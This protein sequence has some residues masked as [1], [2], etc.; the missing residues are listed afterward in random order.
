MSKS[1]Y[2]DNIESGLATV[3][4]ILQ[5]LRSCNS[6]KGGESSEENENHGTQKKL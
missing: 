1:D 4:K 6:E 2:D 5:D 3:A